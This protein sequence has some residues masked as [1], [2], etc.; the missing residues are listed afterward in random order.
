MDPFKQCPNC[1]HLMLHHDIESFDDPKPMCCLDDCDCG[2]T[3][4][5]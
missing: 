3:T 4:T 5:T 1:G 2:T